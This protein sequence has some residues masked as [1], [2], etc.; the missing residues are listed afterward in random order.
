[1]IL[2][3]YIYADVYHKCARGKISRFSLMLAQL[4]NCVFFFNLDQLV[5]RLPKLW[6]FSF[7][8]HSALYFRSFQ[9]GQI[10]R[11]YRHRAKSLFYV[12]C[13]SRLSPKVKRS[14]VNYLSILRE[15]GC[16]SHFLSREEIVLL[17]EQVEFSTRSF[18]FERLGPMPHGVVRVLG[19]FS[20]LSG[21][22]D[23][24]CILCIKPERFHD[25]LT[26]SIYAYYNSEDMRCHED[27]V[28]QLVS[29]G[30]VEKV[31]TP[32]SN[33]F[34]ESWVVSVPKLSLEMFGAQPLALL[35]IINALYIFGWKVIE[36]RGFNF[37][38]GEK[39]Y[40]A[41]YNSSLR[42]SEGKV[43]SE[44]MLLS[45]A[46]HD[47]L[48]NFLF[49]QNFLHKGLVCSDVHLA[50]VASIKADEYLRC[51]EERCHVLLRSY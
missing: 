2:L 39:I 20:D 30:K 38:L 4:A 5:S 22:D 37:Y 25:D 12:V 27:V 3:K 31:L 42:S 28:R 49:L 19:P 44:K 48:I 17:E 40:P 41:E 13:Y 32:N 29:Q 18:R 23:A 26:R 14:A 46:R 10:L 11:A 1:M 8:K 45:L 21:I 36:L 6:I 47:L 24:D 7:I 35:S 33:F 16:L 15:N 43:S 9:S 51:F 50:Y 34:S